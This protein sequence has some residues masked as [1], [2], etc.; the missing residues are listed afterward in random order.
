MSDIL[1]FKD[2]ESLSWKVAIDFIENGNKFIE[3]NGSF[4]AVLTGGNSP[5]RAYQLLAEE[6][7]D[8]IDWSKVHLYWGDERWV[9]HTDE[10]SNAR[11]AR[12]A[13]ISG[14]DIPAD[15]VHFIPKTDDIDKDASTYEDL[16]HRLV[17]KN[18][19]FD[20]VH[21]GVGSDGHVASLFPNMPS[22]QITGAVAFA[23]ENP[24]LG[25]PRITLSKT[26]INQAKNIGFI[27]FGMSKADAVYGIMNNDPA[28]PGSLIQ[29][30]AG[31][32]TWYLDHEA[33]TKVR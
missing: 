15:N 4:H 28:Y 9:P 11:M 29:P 23:T 27:V 18:P 1:Y 7:H 25:E 3:E 19:Q 12:E 33:A 31:N 26:V 5:K 10:R 17:G 24:E 6:F 22:L 20:L 16:I 14:I 32:V 2:I 8:K 21:L 13:L 30:A